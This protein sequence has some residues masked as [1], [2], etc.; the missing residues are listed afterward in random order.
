MKN[1][2]TYA[3]LLAFLT[4]PQFILK[5]Q[6][7]LADTQLTYTININGT[8]TLHDWT[9]VVEEVNA[10]PIYSYSKT[11]INGIME[12]EVT[13]PVHSI[14]SGNRIMDRKMYAAFKSQD[15]PIIK[16]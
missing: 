5:A 6:L 8:S 9:C 1:I 16:F 4:I 15:Y 2:V 14:I 7:L 11:E 3:A 12:L 10:I 13:I